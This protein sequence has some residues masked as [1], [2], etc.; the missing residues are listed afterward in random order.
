MLRAR[1]CLGGMVTAPQHL[2]AET[3]AAVL[4]EGGNAIE[5]M[6]AAAAT[7]AVTYPH[8][9]GIGGDGFWLISRPGE[10]PVA[11]EACGPAAA[12]ASV[13]SYRAEGLEAVPLRGPKAAITIAGAIAGW[14]KALEVSAAIGGRLPLRRL[15]EDAVRHARDGAPVSSSVALRANLKWP[16]LNEAPGYRETFGINGPLQEAGILRQPALVATFERFLEAGL[17]DFYRG[18]LARSMAAD[19]EAA[20]STLRLADFESYSAKFVEPLQIRIAAGEVY[21]LPPPTQ[22]VT[23]LMLI[24]LFESLAVE[25]AETFEHLHG[26]VESAKRAYLLRDAALG[27]PARMRD[28]CR[29]WLDDAFIAREA[30]RIDMAKAS[31]WP[32]PSQEGDTIWMGA[33]DASGNVV[34]Y[35]QSLFKDFGSGVVLPGT[36][37]LWHN[38][39]YSFSLRPGPNEL[40]PGRLP[41][42]TLN[43]AL[44]R[45]DDG[46][47]LAFGTMGGDG[48]PQTLATIFS[49]HILFGQDMQAAITAPRWFLG[50]RPGETRPTLNLESRYPEK[51][52]KAMRT[53][54]HDVALIDPFHDLMGHAGML[55]I[56]QTG[57]IR[58]ATDPRSDGSCV[59][60]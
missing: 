28:D 60:I 58:A 31:P 43:P 5:A 59:G 55:S 42:H 29:A 57:V 40:G 46:R 39:G 45:L 7:I 53:A 11:I 34:S 20:G 49:R 30:A 9:N 13:Q 17:E 47:T 38:R 54:G 26:L 51:L 41:F 18:D 33:A 25:T 8:M 44:A 32:Q 2:A 22:G 15:L 35:I 10:K 50:T 37:V 19:L 52:V 14:Q 21:N 36:G 27:D 12:L 24:K 3:G 56:D 16:E 23:T 48:Q 6:I 4:R 1:T